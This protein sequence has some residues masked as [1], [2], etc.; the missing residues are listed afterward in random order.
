V[1]RGGGWDSEA[2]LVSSTFRVDSH[3]RVALEDIGFRCA[4]SEV[5][6]APS[7][8][9]VTTPTATPEHPT[10]TDFFL[11]C[12]SAAEISDVDARLKITFENDPSVGTLACTAASGSADLTA[13]QKKAYQAIIIMKYLQFDQPLPWTSRQLYDWFT[14][15][16][17]GIRFVYTPYQQ[18][19]DPSNP[20]PKS[21]CCDPMHVIVMNYS[22]INFLMTRDVWTDGEMGVGLADVTS[23]LIH[24]ARHNEFGLH[25]CGNIDKTPD[26]MGASGVQYYFYMWLAYHSD[27]AF[28]QGPPG[29]PDMYRLS[30]LYGANNI[31]NSAFCNEPTQTPGPLLLKP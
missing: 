14:S 10:L 12:P 8:T 21:F 26:E 13:I 15:A 27:P 7:V 25:T 16:I 22:D 3:P 24:E 17:T 1:R 19:Y 28:L 23:L 31:W 29:S 20:P 2:D 18:N 5:T 6:S 30:A 4:Y 9:P 11:R